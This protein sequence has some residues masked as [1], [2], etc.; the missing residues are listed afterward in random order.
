M[1]SFSE[2]YLKNIPVSPQLLHLT[3]VLS[4]YKGKEALYTRQSR[5]AL[6]KLVAWAKVE[7]VESSNRIEGI[8][9][10]HKRVVDIVGQQSTPRNRPEEEVAGYRDA[11]GYIH[12]NYKTLAVSVDGISMFHALLYKYTAQTGGE[13]KWEDNLIVD[14]LDGGDTRIRFTPPP[15]SQTYLYLSRLVQEYQFVSQQGTVSPLI[16]VPLF[17]LDYL[18]I[19]PFRDGNG[20]TARLLALLLLYRAG[21]QVGR[22]NLDQRLQAIF[23]SQIQYG[24]VIPHNCVEA[25][26]CYC[27]YFRLIVGMVPV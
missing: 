13:F 12:E 15:A 20:R 22:L 6:E 19:H 11:L 27:R 14:R 16:S 3:S 18:C 2:E 8:N 10:K 25:G 23:V 9:V 1:K 4:E 24:W 26:L 21:Y 17:V 7:S 5:V